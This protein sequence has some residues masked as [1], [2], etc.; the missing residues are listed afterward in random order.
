MERIFGSGYLDADIVYSPEH[1]AI[2][3][4]AQDYSKGEINRIANM[5]STANVLDLTTRS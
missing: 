5:H 2:L 1:S 4:R 3:S